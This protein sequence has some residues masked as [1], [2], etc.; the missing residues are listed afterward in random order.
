MKRT[1]MQKINDVTAFGI[2]A[3]SV[4]Y[5]IKKECEKSG[6][7]NT[8]KTAHPRSEKL[9]TLG[10]YYITRLDKLNNN[11][12][13]L[14][15]RKRNYD[16][17]C[18]DTTL[19]LKLT[20]EQL[21]ILSKTKHYSVNEEPVTF[22]CGG[23]YIYEWFGTDGI[24]GACNSKHNETYDHINARV[25]VLNTIDFAVVTITYYEENDGDEIIRQNFAIKIDYREDTSEFRSLTARVNLV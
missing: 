10:S 11:E 15:L 7:K 8:K 14:E 12:N 6:K 13:Y 19:A 1:I 3:A 25:S 5:S 9:A 23:G 20:D 21:D 2:M 22:I 17:E 18:C 16:P 24:N 4:V